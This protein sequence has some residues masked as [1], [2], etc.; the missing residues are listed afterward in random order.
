MMK[1]E[2]E[3][4]SALCEHRVFN[5][6]GVKATYEDFGEKYDRSPETADPYCCADMRFTSNLPTQ[7]V[8]D[9]YKITTDEYKQI[10]E[11]LEEKMSYGCCGWCE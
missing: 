9:K 10:C 5:I 8:L 3:M 2:F 4:Y 7:E 1:L 11:M 6:N